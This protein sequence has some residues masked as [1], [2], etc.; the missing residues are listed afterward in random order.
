MMSPFDAP[1]P[2]EDLA[3]LDG[4]EDR[5]IEPATKAP[6]PDPKADIIT[7]DGA[8][9]LFA[10][11]HADSLRFCHSTGAWYEWN[12][13]AWRLDQTERA[14]QWAREMARRLAADASPRAR[15][16]TSKVAFARAVETFASCDPALSVTIE[17]W[18][19]DP[20]LL[21]TPGGTVDLRT[22]ELRDAKPREGI[23]KLT[24]VTPDDAPNCPTW[25]Q[26]LHDVTQGDAGYIRFIQQWAGYCLTGDTSEQ[27][28]CFAYGGGGNGKGVLIHVLAGILKEY[29]V[30]A[31]METFTASKHDRHPTEIARLRGA[32]LVTASETEQGRQWAESRIK[33]LTGGDTMSA[34]F[35]R[36]DDFEFVPV[37]K[38]LI[39][40]NNKP[41]LSSVD[42]AARRRFN[43]LPFLFKP[44][45]PDP[46]LEEKLK[47]EWPAI[48]RWMIE[49]CLDWQANRLVRP[50]VVK[51]ATDEYFTAQDTFSQWLDVTLSGRRC[52]C[53]SY[54][55]SPSASAAWP[56][57]S[58]PQR[59][60][61]IT[62]SLTVARQTFFGGARS[63]APASPAM[64]SMPSEKRT[65]A[66]RGR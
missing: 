55:H 32:R 36:Q 24:A 31:A 26:F 41:A 4:Y 62:L 52:G 65:A 3:H 58:S 51:D 37:L 56:P 18:D 5:K 9:C 35:M 29:A 44:A 42:D 63:R 19:A 59:P 57:T 60:S 53:V 34:H 7:E 10:A 38:L 15:Y 20:W 2:L 11:A 13:S 22:G 27:A 6:A 33:Q 43:L 8:A 45:K 21:G 46:S 14:L 28:L 12:G 17:N 16:M 61:V 48:L 40:G 50:E 30:N 47:A 64:T 25:L 23:T 54:R 39:I 66:R 49:G 1:L